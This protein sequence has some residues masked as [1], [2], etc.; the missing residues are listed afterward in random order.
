MVVIAAWPVELLSDMLRV[1]VLW[2]WGGVYSDTDVLSI[3]PFTLPLNALGF[4]SDH[5]V[6]SAFYSFHAHHPLL[7]DLMKDMN[8]NFKVISSSLVV[9][10]INGG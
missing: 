1:L 4:E 6:G 2:R 8:K 5:Q 10:I 7:L 9:H 3:R